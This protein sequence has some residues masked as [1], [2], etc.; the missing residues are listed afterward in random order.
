M[1]P[2]HLQ[3]PEHGMVHR[4]AGRRF[5]TINAAGRAKVECALARL[6]QDRV[7]ES[8]KIDQQLTLIGVAID[9]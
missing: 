6:A 8:V 4:L 2:L 1:R 9:N 7:T 5:G 3:L